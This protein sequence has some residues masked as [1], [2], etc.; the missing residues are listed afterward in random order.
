M[1]SKRILII[2]D[3]FIQYGAEKILLWLGHSLGQIQNNEVEFVSMFDTIREKGIDSLFPSHEFGIS[4]KGIF[5]VRNYKYFT[6]GYKKLKTIFNHKKY[7]YVL[8]FGQKSYYILLIL[9]NTYKFRIIL[10]ERNDPFH[11][12]KIISH[13]NKLLYNKADKIVFQTEGAKTFYN[14]LNNQNISIIPN[15]IEIPKEEWDL[16]FTNKSIINIGR[17]DIEQ[18][19]QDLLL[20]AFKKIQYKYPDYHLELIGDGKD[21]LKL[22]LLAKNLGISDKVIFRGR[23]N[24]VNSYLLHASVFVFTSDYE[25]M[26]NA[27]MEAMALGMPVISTNCSPGGAKALIE[28]G[29]NGLLVDCGDEASLYNAISELIS[30]PEVAI[31]YGRQARKSMLKY[32][33]NIIFYK[34]NNLFL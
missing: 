3:S 22:E 20:N 9:R 7:D 10:S 11:T 12:K 6:E 18:K 19:R 2:S 24:N 25:G 16:A 31:S 34:W 30:N 5:I 33:P 21:K 26:P 29:E 15:P 1:N 8:S 13:I 27:L 4:R 32:A 23:V 28:S 14:N 17:L